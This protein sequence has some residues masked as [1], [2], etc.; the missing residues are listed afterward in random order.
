MDSDTH[1]RRA[2][3]SAM[4][5]KGLTQAELARRLGKTPQSVAPIL[6]GRR[7]KQPESLLE[8]LDALGLELK[9]VP[10][11]RP[12]T[13]PPDLASLLEDAGPLELRSG[14]GRPKGS[15]VTLRGGTSVAD[16]VIA[17][18]QEREHSL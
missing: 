2:I 3:E 5:E 1:I 18:R 15:T 16:T 11:G 12:E 14:K 13:L 9:V 17:E 4:R 10:K 8:V 6:K 7:G